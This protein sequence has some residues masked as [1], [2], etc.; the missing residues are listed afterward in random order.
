LGAAVLTYLLTRDIRSTISVVIVAGACGIAAGTPLAILGAIGRAARAGA[1]IKGGLFLEQLGR[2]DTVV[3]DKTGTLTYGRPE[4]R[5]LVP[6]AGVDELTLLDA[7]AAAEIRSEHPLGKTIVGHARAIGRPAREPESFAYTPGRGIDAVVDG[8]RVLVGN[9]VLMRAN[10]IAVP[11]DLFAQYPEATEVLVARAGRLL[12][13]VVIADT[14]RAEAAQAIQTIQSMGINTVLLTGDAQAVAT[15]IAR[16]LGISEVA[17]DLLPED[18]RRRVKELVDQGRTVAM[19]GDGINDAPALIEAHV[20]VSMG[21]GTDVARESADVVLLGNDLLKFAE[22][23]AIAR[24]TRRIIWANF[25]GTIGVDTLGIALAA[26][27]LLNPLLA[28]FIH[29]AS[30]MTF[31]LNSARLLPGREP[32]HERVMERPGEAQPGV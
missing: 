23:L 26:F 11:S 1:I 10:G 30:E 21:S 8:S 22:T 13:A 20:G 32:R 12:G 29:V 27:G 9:Q 19:V 5:A 7:A 18:K 6:V 24:R 2:V 17:A 15:V 31:I 14:L 3:L 16:Q 28:A 25:A 4:V